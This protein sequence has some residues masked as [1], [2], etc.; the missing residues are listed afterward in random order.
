MN[1]LLYAPLKPPVVHGQNL[2]G[3]HV[4]GMSRVFSVNMLRHL[5]SS[6]ARPPMFGEA[7]LQRALCFTDVAGVT[8]L[9]RNMVNRPNHLFLGQFV[10]GPHQ[11][12]PDRVCGFEIC[13]DPIFLVSPAKFLRHPLHVGDNNGVLPGLL[14]TRRSVV[15][16]VLEAILVYL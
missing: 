4:Y 16:Y 8:V 15:V 12:L 5:G 9:T 2:G 14:F 10:F 7:G 11:D 13:R 3:L 6:G 1:G